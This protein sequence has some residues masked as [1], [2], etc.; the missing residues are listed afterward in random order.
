MGGR[1]PGQGMAY[2]G[3]GK[4]GLA[5]EKSHWELFLMTLPYIWPKNNLK[6]K[7]H[8][9][10]S[11]FFLFCGK[12]CELLVPILFARTINRVVE[13]AEGRRESDINEMVTPILLYSALRFGSSF[14]QEV[15]NITFAYVAAYTERKVALKSFTHLQDLSLRF[16][17][18]RKTGSVIRSVSRGSS[19][20]AAISRIL[21][22]QILPVFLQVIVVCV[23]LLIEY[24]WWF[25]IITLVTIALY[26]LFTLTTTEWRNKFRRTMNTADNEYNQ[27]A[28]DALLNFE[29]V[30][31]FNAEQH[32]KRRFDSS[33]L[34]YQSANI[35]STQSLALLNAGQSFI[36]AL[37]VLVA[38]LLAAK[39]VADGDMD[40][41]DFVLI[42]QFII[43]LYLPLGFLGTYYR[44]IKQNFVDVENMTNLLDEEVEVQ[45]KPDAENLEVNGGGIS[46][47]KVSFEYNEGE[48]IL[49]D[50]SFEVKPGE[51]VAIVGRSGAGKS[52]LARLLYRF[53]DV[54]S[55]DIKIDGKS[56]RDVTQYSLRQ[57]IAIVPQDCVLFNDSIAYNINY[58]SVGEKP[59][60][61]V[62]GEEFEDNVEERMPLIEE[63]AKNASIHDFVIT[64][65]A[66]Y[67]TVVGERGLR[68]SGG[69]KQ[70]VAIARAIL[71]K[72]KI[73]V[74]DEATSSLDTTTEREIQGALDVVSEGR[75]TITV[76]HRLSTIVNSDKIIVLRKGQISE[77]G[78]HDELM[79]KGSDGEYFNM[80]KRQ[81][82]NAQLE[83][84]LMAL[85]K[86]EE[87]EVLG[88]KAELSICEIVEEKERE[89]EEKEEQE[90]VAPSQGSSDETKE[91]AGK[92]VEEKEEEEDED[93]PLVHDKKEE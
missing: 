81:Q 39:E 74:F 77:M 6:V 30:K 88:D 35:T 57:H 28:V 13:V 12:A 73:I 63:A 45:D 33:L 82:Q 32:E 90:D 84:E 61:E 34:T 5:V 59:K 76:A 87:L 66:Q 54:K 80:W 8:V 62:N 22:F 43:T 65:K 67:G 16:H 25:A 36:I 91:E 89:E 75:T 1:R 38:M 3:K 37:G 58:G 17:L 69:E 40:A 15:R 19:S 72:P 11:F 49:K 23:F 64:Q 4:S 53:Y 26:F 68:L 2:D 92:E 20:F 78:T 42:N 83:Q 21:L 79:A 60:E 31:Y 46:F 85:Q 48:P 14:F 7:L 10:V 29:T 27:K 9:I 50:L 52:T 41:G 55:G 93:A 44:M 70:R 24:D 56:L 51:K 86:E 71:K 47:E 18:N